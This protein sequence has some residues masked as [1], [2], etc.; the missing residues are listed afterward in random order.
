M[1]KG[2]LDTNGLVRDGVD[3]G[4]DGGGNL[5]HSVGLGLVDKGLGD[6]LDGPHGSSN[7]LTSESWDIL[8][9]GLSNMGGLSHG[10]GDGGDLGAHLSKSMG[11][12]GGIGKVA[13]QSVVL[14]G[15]GVMSGS[16]HQEG[17]GSCNS[18][19][20]NSSGGNSNSGC[21]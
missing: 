11:L 7:S 18:N 10:V 6:L 4:V 16:P 5:L 3:W 12:G 13:S 2:P 20:S 15:S 8:E 9:D 21:A 19:G 14:D 17:G 1:L